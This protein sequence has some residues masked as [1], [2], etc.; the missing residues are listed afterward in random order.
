MK[1]LLIIACIA[2][3]AV[4]P[5][6][7]QDVREAVKKAEA[8]RAAAE[9]HAKDVEAKILADRDALLAQVTDLE[10]RQKTLDT[11]IKALQSKRAVAQDRH[12]KLQEKWSTKEVD[13][14]EL[15][16]NVR[17]AAGDVEALVQLLR[18]EHGERSGQ[19]A[20]LASSASPE[21]L[22][23]IARWLDEAGTEPA[24]AVK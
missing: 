2:L 17:M 24:G 19:P 20:A 3:I 18:W 14:R 6:L 7:A 11:E 4:T 12:D 22:A 13:F 9:A 10:A 5:A 15:Q 23:Q 16:G 21:T 8:D 1:K